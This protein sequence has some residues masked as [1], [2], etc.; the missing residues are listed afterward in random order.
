M[1]TRGSTTSSSRTSCWCASWYYNHSE[2]SSAGSEQFFDDFFGYHN[3]GA[4]TVYHKPTS[5]MSQQTMNSYYFRMNHTFRDK[6]LLGFTLRADGASNF[7]ANNKYGW[8]PSASAAWIISEEPFFDAARKW[9][10][11]LK[12]RASYGT[13]GNASIPNYSTISQYSNDQ[14][15][16]NGALNPYVVL[17]NLGNADLKWETSKQFNVG[18][19]VSLFDNRLELIMDYYNKTTTDLLFQKQVP[20]T[21]GYATTWTNLGKIRNKGFELTISSRNINHKNFQ[22]TT[23]LVFS[24]NRL[25]VIDVG[26]ERIDLGNNA[27]AEAGKPWG[28]FFV[29]NRLGT[30]GLDEVDEARKYGKKPG[31]LKFEDRNHDYVIDDNDRRIMGNGTPKGDITL[32]NTFRYKGFSLMVDLNAAYGFKIMGITTTMMENRQLYGNSMK[33]VLNAWTPENQNSMIA[34]LRLPSDVNFGENEKDSRMLYDGDFLRIRNISLSYDF[35]PELLRKL[36]VIK[37]LSIGVNVE[38]LHVFTEYPGYDP[39]V[40]AFNT[41]RGQSIDFYSYPHPTTVS[42]NIKITF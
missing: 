17:S 15:I 34:A 7:G 41:D 3:L 8:F 28:S 21:T 13:V 16:L 26:G 42:A 2:N 40:G 12:L 27:I 29:L 4:G 23:D 6:Y 18:L 25:M 33:S 35:K 1:P 39:E 11:N 31:D 37:G 30:W 10:S 38:N 36:R 9:V 32:V 5:G 24:T 14:M 19:D 22:W 20:Y